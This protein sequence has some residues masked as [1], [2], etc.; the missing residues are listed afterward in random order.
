MIFVTNKAYCC[1]NLFKV[2]Q[3]YLSL[4][5]IRGAYAGL[6]HKFVSHRIEYTYIEESF[7]K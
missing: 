4:T 1:A 3:S 6:E 7:H 2:E 5:K